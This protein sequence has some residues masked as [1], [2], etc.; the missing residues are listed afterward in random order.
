MTFSNG[1]STRPPK[2][3]HSTKSLMVEISSPLKRTKIT[4]SLVDVFVNCIYLAEKIP[5]FVTPE[6]I[7]SAGP[8]RR[9]S[10]VVD[11]SCDTTNPHNPIPIY[12][13][14][15]TFDKPTV[16]A[17][18]G[19]VFELTVRTLANILMESNT[20]RVIP[21]YRSCPLTIFQRCYHGR[22][23]NNSAPISCLPCSSSPNALR[24][25][26]GQKRRRCSV[27]NSQR[28]SRSRALRNTS[29][30]QL[31]SEKFCDG[32]S[33]RGDN[34]SVTVFGSGL[35]GKKQGYPL[36]IRSRS[37]SPNPSECYPLERTVSVEPPYQLASQK[38]VFEVRVWVTKGFQSDKRTP[39]H[40]LERIIPPPLLYRQIFDP[41][42]PR[43]S[44][45]TLLSSTLAATCSCLAGSINDTNVFRTSLTTSTCRLSNVSVMANTP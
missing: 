22:R 12:N 1:I 26:F 32:R 14:N 24:R 42:Q 28:L 44:L 3:G 9:L 36:A 5:H 43:F 29:C 23:P 34:R 35:S 21:R 8:S 6:Q 10:V 18:V 19:C 20:E 13:I 2:G 33:Q 11:V 40:P 39:L 41:H 4:R 37:S 17:H 15:T 27:R 45:S 38:I 31:S 16:E 7:E 30:D 25:A